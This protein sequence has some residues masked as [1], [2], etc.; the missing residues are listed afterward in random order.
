MFF[1]EYRKISKNTYFEEDLRT[2]ASEVTLESDCLGLS[3]W[4]VAF[5]TNLT[6]S[7]QSFKHNL[8]HIPSLNL[9]P[10]LSFEPGFACSSLTLVVPGLLVAFA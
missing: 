5:K 4:T 8:A 7:N 1:C 9:T 3:F 6:L 2:A 10:T